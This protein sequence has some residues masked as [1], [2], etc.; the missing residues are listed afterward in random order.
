MLEGN[1]RLGPA[2]SARA[3]PPAKPGPRTGSRSPRA[4][5]PLR[6]RLPSP[7][8]HPSDLPRACLDPS[9]WTPRSRRARQLS[10]S[11]RRAS[12][13][14]IAGRP[15]VSWVAAVYLGVTTTMALAEPTDISYERAFEEHWTDVFRFALAW[16]NDW[17][18]AEDLGQE[19]FLRL[20]NHLS[21]L[22]WSRPVLL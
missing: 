5:G 12:T 17:T 21:R 18:A 2:P 11:W 15:C 19:A 9:L 22:D 3:R 6:M 7:V 20:W 16:T 8:R 1:A 13:L 4:S 14:R 10:T